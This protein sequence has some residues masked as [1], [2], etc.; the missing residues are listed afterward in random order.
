MSNIVLSCDQIERALRQRSPV[1]STA[2]HLRPAAVLIPLFARPEDGSTRLWLLQR[3]DDGSPHGGQVALPGGKPV[4]AD[5]DLCQTALREAWEEIG[6][7]P[8]GAKVMGVLDDYVTVTGF[9]I[10]PYVGWISSD[11]IPVPNPKE[12]QR[13]FD[14]PLS[15]FLQSGERHWV[16]WASR[17]RMV[18]CY[19]VGDAVVWGATA[20]ILR[21]F[22]QVIAAAT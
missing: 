20:A 7:P 14:A 1:R 13:C 4:F 19:V 9:R 15:L 17:R 16:R 8:T 12:V 5:Q 2:T 21:S 22:G 11:F 3:T 6:I 18:R 10:S